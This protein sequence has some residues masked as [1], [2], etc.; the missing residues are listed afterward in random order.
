MG[1]PRARAVACLGKPAHRMGDRA[2]PNVI[3][4]AQE[5]LPLSRPSYLLE[6]TEL[7]LYACNSN[8]TYVKS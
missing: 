4:K 7:A 2:G 1:P 5:T 6:V 3:M 8:V